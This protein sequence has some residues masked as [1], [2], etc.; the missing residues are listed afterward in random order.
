MKANEV[1][2]W[3]C[4]VSCAVPRLAEIPLSEDEERRAAVLLFDSDRQLFT[5]SHRLLRAVLSAYLD[6]NHRKLCLAVAEN[7]KPF[8]RENRNFEFNL[9]HASDGAVVA[10]AWQ[11]PV[12]VDI[13]APVL[14]GSKPLDLAP[15]AEFCLTDTER[16]LC[17]ANPDPGTFLQ[18]WTRK[19]ALLKACGRGLTIPL[20]ELVVDFPVERPREHFTALSQW[21]EEWLVADLDVGPPWR[22]T[23]AVRGSARVRLKKF[24]LGW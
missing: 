11:R 14:S 3:R 24:C 4:R 2:L 7:G 19:E 23:V 13:E 5:L 21:G 18:L 6:V 20:Q 8:A 10:L 12:G 22:G 15:L 1:H 16:A 17:V 9:S